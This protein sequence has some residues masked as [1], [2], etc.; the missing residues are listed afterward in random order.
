[1][2]SLNDNL[3]NAFRQ[4]R[5]V[6][7]YDKTGE[8]R[9]QYD[10]IDLAEVEKVVMNQNAFAIKYRILR[11]ER[12]QKFLLYFPY[13]RPDNS[14]NWLLDIELSNFVFDT[15]QSALYLQDMG[16]DYTYKALVQEHIQFFGAKDRRLQFIELFNQS[17]SQ[18]ILKHKMLSIVFSTD[19]YDLQTLV[20][21]YAN[22][23]FSN[24]DK[25]NKD[26]ER[27]NLRQF[28][29]Q[30]IKDKYKYKGEGQNIYEFI[31]E[32]FEK[33]FF[34]TL[35]TGL[36][37]DARLILSSWRD[38]YTMR[39]SYQKIS[40]EI[41]EI[42]KV[43]DLLQNAHLENIVDDEL[44]ELTDKK[45]IY[46]LVHHLL[47]RDIS[48]DRFQKIIKTRESKFWFPIY[49]HVYRALE[50]AFALFDQI[51]KLQTEHNSA[52]LAIKSY[53][54][55]DYRIDFF[56]RK[57]YEH[58][59]RAEKSNIIKHLVERVEKVYVNDWLF[60]HGNNY[61]KLLNKKT[62]WNF[63]GM[64]MQRDFFKKKVSPILEK[65]KI[66]V[67]IS[68]ALRY[69]C[70]VELTTEINKISRFRAEQE[71][72]VSVVPSYTQIGMA[73]LLPHQRLSFNQE[74]D[75]ILVD[76]LSSLGSENREKILTYTTQR[77]AVTMHAGEF[78][79]MKNTDRRTIIRDYEIVYIYS[80][81]IDKV[82]DDKMT[83]TEVFDAVREEIMHLKELVVAVTSANAPRV[84]V[85]TDHGF[86][87]QDSAVEESDFVETK[88]KGETFKENRRFVLGTKLMADDPAMHFKAADLG[89][90]SDCE[91]LIAKGINRFKVKGAGSR[92][93]HGGASLQETII[94]LLD[95]S[96]GRE[97]TVQPVEIDIIQSHNKIT[98]NS[99]PIEFVQKEAISD[100][101]LPV[102]VQAFIQA[103]DGKVLSDTFSFNFDFTGSEH[104][105]RSKKFVFHMVS[106]ASHAY[107]NQM[108]DLILQTPIEN[109]NRW[110]DYKR[111]S[112]HLNISFTNDFD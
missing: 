65:Q 4:N 30:E 106:E 63:T 97:E 22:S 94:P 41:A 7:W 79:K 102:E 9:E 75:S 36:A 91:I 56:Y 37:A 109:T 83:E 67:I 20:Q 64:F 53:I 89:I 100:K 60:T 14:N 57:F 52:E 66:V 25:L 87:Y 35:K 105:Q 80:N 45:I 23:Y 16:L 108:V 99:L 42:L 49:K 111:F 3:E 61:Q 8:S 98:T 48:P 71:M 32:V 73:S 39:E 103:A 2:S 38:S 24:L 58:F 110:K 68:D 86:I 112:Y 28:I 44:F 82:G 19:S 90:D 85:T 51:N 34:L 13:E 12:K 104:R 18:R 95:I 54:E 93:V 27:Y 101:I 33:S 92:F 46:E 1:M 55:Q 29:W 70:G 96:K 31:I 26:L 84:L 6:F 21:S 17:D 62:N 74:T 81:K 43:E 107:R 88:F 5:V 15:E 10:E 72:M 78:L 47:N 59:H 77:T 50:N 69:E 40:G 11:E 76:G